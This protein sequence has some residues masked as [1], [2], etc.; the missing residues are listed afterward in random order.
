MK[1]KIPCYSPCIYY[2]IAVVF[3]DIRQLRTASSLSYLIT[4][5]V[6]SV[7]KQ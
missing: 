6:Y 4:L 7:Y 3:S 1:G 2:L 5:C